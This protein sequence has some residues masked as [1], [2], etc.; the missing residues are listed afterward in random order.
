MKTEDIKAKAIRNHDMGLI[1]QAHGFG[2][3]KTPNCA[4]KVLR[5]AAVKPLNEYAQDILRICEASVN[6]PESGITGEVRFYDDNSITFLSDEEFAETSR[7]IAEEAAAMLN[8][9]E[10]IQPVANTDTV[11]RYSVG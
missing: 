3:N 8:F 2:L 1:A 7:R 10:P 4:I 5:K 6:T 11:I 9:D